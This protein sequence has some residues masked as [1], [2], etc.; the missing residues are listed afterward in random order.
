MAIAVEIQS[1]AT[2]KQYEQQLDDLGLTPFGTGVP[3]VLF[4]WAAEQEDGRLHVVEVWESREKFEIFLGTV[5]GPAIARTG[6]TELPELT[7]YDIRNYLTP[8]GFPASVAAL[9]TLWT[10]PVPVPDD[11]DF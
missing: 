3:G 8:P 6:V 11:D 1:I 4:H 7:F 9:P 5:L 10:D 2:M